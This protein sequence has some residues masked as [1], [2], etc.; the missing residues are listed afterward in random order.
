MSNTYQFPAMKNLS[1][2]DIQCQLE[3]I[4]E[5]IKEAVKACEYY[6][7]RQLTT[8]YAS[9]QAEKAREEYLMEL[10]DITHCVETALRMEDVNEEEYSRI[11]E[12]VIKKNRKRG[13]YE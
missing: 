10:M 6:D 13:Y 5:E 8:G 9:P 1:D 12:L 2:W 4:E 3:K 11:R 7:Y